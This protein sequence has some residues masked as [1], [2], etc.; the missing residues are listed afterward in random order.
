[1]S[2]LRLWIVSVASAANEVYG[3]GGVIVARASLK[4]VRGLRSGSKQKTADPFG[5]IVWVLLETHGD[6]TTNRRYLRAKPTKRSAREIGLFQRTPNSKFIGNTA[7][8]KL[9]ERTVA[10]CER[11]K[12]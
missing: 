9:A 11:S 4:T 1:M 10:A 8:A 2:T 6:H 7:I 5:E 12:R 3:S